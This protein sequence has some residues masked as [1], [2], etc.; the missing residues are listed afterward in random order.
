MIPPEISVLLRYHNQNKGKY[1]EGQIVMYSQYV[2]YEGVGTLAAANIIINDIFLSYYLLW[3]DMNIPC[4]DM[5]IIPISS[6]REMSFSTAIS[7]SRPI[8]IEKSLT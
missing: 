7:P 5:G 2:D 3:F 4:V 6:D 1:R 8:S